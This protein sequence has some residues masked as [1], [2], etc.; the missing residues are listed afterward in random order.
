MA[1]L[2]SSSSLRFSPLQNRPE[3]LPPSVWR[4]SELGASAAPV[5]ASGWASLDAELPGGGWPCRALTEVLLAH[6]GTLEW[7]LLGHALRAVVA[8]G[9]TVVLIGAPALLPCDGAPHGN[10]RDMLGRT[11]PS[12]WPGPQVGASARNAGWYA[13]QG[14]DASARDAPMR[15]P[16]HPLSTSESGSESESGQG[17]E[18]RGMQ[19]EPR[20]APMLQPHLPGVWPHGLDAAHLIWIDPATP[21]DALWATEQLIRA[22]QAGAVLSWLPQAR[23][24]QVRRLQMSAQ[25]FDGLSLVVRPEAAQAQASAAPLRVQ[26]QA[27]PMC[28]LAIRVLK[29]RGPT[30]VD[31]LAV[32]AVPAGLHNVLNQYPQKEAISLHAPTHGQ[33]AAEQGAPL[34]A[35]V[36]HPAN[37]AADPVVRGLEQVPARRTAVAP[38]PVM[39][40]AALACAQAQAHGP[41]G[42]SVQAPAAPVVLAASALLGAPAVPVRATPSAQ[43]PVPVPVPARRPIQQSLHWADAQPAKPMGLPA[44]A[45]GAKRR[46]NAAMPAAPAQWPTTPMATSDVRQAARIARATA[47]SQGPARRHARGAAS[48]VRR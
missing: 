47:T 5:Q 3:T 22:N 14:G 28:Q 45:T 32:P 7:R 27:A 23:P 36:Q 12:G 20:R 19:P 38:K 15:T 17:Q 39:Q 8:Q 33:A 9:Q 30:H 18:R 44:V 26:V 34:H 42:S 4:G 31:W 46:A 6:P 11:R 1:S 35:F 16:R 21:A 24:E 43:V 13:S 29:R 37:G 48:G 25:G 41:V 40:V 10:A 2:H